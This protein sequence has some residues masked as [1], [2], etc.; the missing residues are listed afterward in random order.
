MLH[1]LDMQ[2]HFRRNLIKVQ[3]SLPCPHILMYNYY[4]KIGGGGCLHPYLSNCLIPEACQPVDSCTS[5]R[6]RVSFSEST[7]CSYMQCCICAKLLRLTWHSTYSLGALVAVS[8]IIP[9]AC[10]V[11]PG[12]EYKNILHI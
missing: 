4:L 7:S 9:K 1:F 10:Q 2:V 12:L 8:N 5:G 11:Y 6:I 3:L